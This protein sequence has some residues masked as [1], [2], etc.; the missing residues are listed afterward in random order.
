MPGHTNAALTPIPELNSTGVRAQPRYD[1]AV[2][3]STLM[4]RSEATYDFV[5]DVIS[6]LAAISPSQYIHIGGD[7]SFSTSA[8]DYDY[9]IGRVASIVNKY[10]KKVVGWDPYDTSTGITSSDSIL[11]NWHSTPSTGTSAISKGMKMILS[12][13]NAYI[14]QKYYPDSPLG[15]SWRGYI[16]TNKA[17]NWDPTDFSHAAS[18]YGIE[19]TLW[20]ETV[21]TQDNLDYMIYPRLIA[22]A[23]VGWT[24]KSSRNWTDFKTRL[25]NHASSLENKGI[26]YF[27]DP[28][29]FSPP[30]PP[31]NSKWSMDEGTGT[32][33]SENSGR[34]NATLL[35]TTT[36][37][38][39]WTTGKFGNAISLNG[40]S[41]YISLGGTEISGDWTLGMWVNGRS[42]TT[43]SAEALV[44]GP[45][46]SI[47]ANQWNKTGKV[48]F[49]VFGVKDSSFN[50]KLPTTNTW[51]HLTFV[52][53]SAGTSLYVNGV[54]NQ[55]IQIK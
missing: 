24:P 28:I 5:D 54:L 49:S 41:Q 9:F 30:A 12:P 44:S 23:E 51:V 46:S 16:N 7:E 32:T 14:D 4:A 42:N 10:G 3:Y 13:A 37:L 26:K 38:P 53:S 43:K 52:G 25:Y 1:T 17:Y 6:E 27:A 48:G 19:S 31:I 11:Q 22:N 35:S 34:Y 21:V 29:A 47:K 20:T 50:Y 39:I 36:T 18:I 33:A 8:A 45:T 2:G 40:T 15:L 55:T